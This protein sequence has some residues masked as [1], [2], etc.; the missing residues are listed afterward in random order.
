MTCHHLNIL[1]TNII[2][3]FLEKYETRLI[4]FIYNLKYTM[5]CSPNS[6]LTARHC[7]QSI[8]RAFAN[9]NMPAV[10]R[11]LITLCRNPLGNVE[12]ELSEKVKRCSRCQKGTCTNYIQKQLISLRAVNIFTS[13]SE[14]DIN[15]D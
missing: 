3:S 11:S 9:G 6:R 4:V 13:V 10:A 1:A 7:T 12:L 2:L 5:K 15:M 14:E 8:T